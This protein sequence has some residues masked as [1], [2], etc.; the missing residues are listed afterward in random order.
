MK[1][2]NELF[3]IISGI[4]TV[5]LALLFISLFAGTIVWLLWPIVIP[6]VFPGLVANGSIVG[7]I[8]WWHAVCFTWFCGILLSGSHYTTKEDK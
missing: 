1:I 5:F 4:G 3:T 2:L 8:A 7:E 6:N